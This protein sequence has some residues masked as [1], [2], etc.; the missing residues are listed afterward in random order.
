MTAGLPPQ[1]FVDAVDVD[2]VG[3]MNLIHASMKHLH[4]GASIIT[5][6]RWPPSCD[7]GQHQRDGRRT[8]GAGYAFAKQVVAH[9]VNDLARTLGRSRS[10]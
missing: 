10:A 2:L 3:V 6:D 5:T 9:Y 7:G 1:A 4:A 8:G